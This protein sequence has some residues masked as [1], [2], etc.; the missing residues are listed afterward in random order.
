L[1]IVSCL[2]TKTI[3]R[4]DRKAI[5][6]VE[7]NMVDHG[8]AIKFTEVANDAEDRVRRI[9]K[10]PVRIGARKGAPIN[11]AND[12]GPTDPKASRFLVL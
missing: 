2:T 5:V 11:A 9:T 10:T 7:K 1:L 4:K 8:V 12:R 3:A 6:R